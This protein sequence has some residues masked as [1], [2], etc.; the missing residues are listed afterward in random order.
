L[1]LYLLSDLIKYLISSKIVILCIALLHGVLRDLKT[2][3][4]EK[5]LPQKQKK[6]KKPYHKNKKSGKNPTTKTKKVEKTLP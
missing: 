1:F 2:K 3:K 6:R 5:T 4:A